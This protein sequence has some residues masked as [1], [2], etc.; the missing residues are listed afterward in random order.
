MA[1]ADIPESI[2]E[3][4]VDFASHW[5]EKWE[6][7]NPFVPL[8]LEPLKQ[9]GVTLADFAFKQDAKNVAEVGLIISVVKMRSNIRVG[10]DSIIFRTSNPDWEMAPQLVLLFD[11][12]LDQLKSFV[13]VPIKSQEATLAFHA[14]E[15]GVEIGMRTERLVNARL[16]GSAQFYGVSTF[17]PENT[18]L[19]ERSLK[20]N[21]GAFFRLTRVFGESVKFAEIALALYEDEVSALKLIGIEGVV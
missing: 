13:L 5:L 7:P 20:F 6:L 19:L 21:G 14:T 11:T 16:L 12:V 9:W 8:L 2:I 15:E 18:L 10:V 1:K 3:H 4:R 17:G